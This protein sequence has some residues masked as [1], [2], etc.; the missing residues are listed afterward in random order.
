MSKNIHIHKIYTKS[1]DEGKTQIIGQKARISKANLQIEAYGCTDELVS[2]LGFALSLMHQHQNKFPNQI[3]FNKIIKWLKR[4]Q[5]NLFDIGSILATSPKARPQKLFSEEK[6][7][8]LEK[9][10]DDLQL[11]LTPLTSFVLAG[12]HVLNS[13]FHI[14][15]TVCR[16][17]ERIIIKLHESQ[18]LDAIVIKYINR[19]SDLFFALARWTSSVLKEKE[20]LWLPGE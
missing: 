11:S 4:I 6:V 20:R 14:C 5:N 16:K 2:H 9:A 7:I 15:R 10:I 12:G 1:G 19:L 17:A 18:K 13:Q 3:E 8:F